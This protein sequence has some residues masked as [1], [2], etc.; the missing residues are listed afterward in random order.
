MMNFADI[1]AEKAKRAGIIFSQEQL[2]RFTV[3]FVELIQTNEKINLTAITNPEEVAV[4]HFIDCLTVYDDKYFPDG[5]KICDVG[6]GAG[7]P[8]LPLKIYK[9][10]LQVAL[11]DSLAKRL[12]FLNELIVQLKLKGVKTFHSRAED[13]GRSAQHRG[14]YDVVLARAVAPLNILCEYCLPLVKT[15]GVFVAMKAKQGEEELRYA[16]QA[17]EML[18]A[19]VLE[20]RKIQL[21]GLIDERVAIYMRKNKSTPA[22]YP[23]KAGT[24]GKNP[25]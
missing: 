21:P 1:L 9:D 15:G 11:L 20:I 23:R 16:Q 12:I 8:G 24:P 19:Q 17:I 22:I 4:K 3:Y 14:K 10:K 6:T 13:A 18:G 25:L 2:D 5:A 7:F